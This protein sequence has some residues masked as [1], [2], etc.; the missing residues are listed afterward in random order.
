MHGISSVSATEREGYEYRNG[1]S[2]STPHVTGCAAL[3]LSYALE[4][5]KSYTAKE[6]KHLLLTSV[7]DIDKYQAGTKTIVYPSITTID[8]TRYV[9]QLGA[10]YIDAHL[11]LM[12]IEDTPCLYVKTG[13]SAQL[14]LDEFFGAASEDLTYQ[15]V[16]LSDAARSALGITTTPTISNG[17]LDI[18][19]TKSGVGRIKITAI[20][21]G[22][23]VGGGNNM[24][25]MLVEREVEVVA[26]GS[27]ASNGGWL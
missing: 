9:G 4:L 6:F 14:S 22:S 21:G 12:Q 13:S 2:H 11:L 25:G 5:G 26:R 23:A 17:L 20:V 27:V 24:G 15:G 18:K 10:G 19:C 7:Q 8:M 16:E 1:T 3:G